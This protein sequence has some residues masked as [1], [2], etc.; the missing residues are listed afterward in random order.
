MA[1]E[2]REPIAP[3][4]FPGSGRSVQKGSSGAHQSTPGGTS[5]S[6][7]GSGQA[8]GPTPGEDGDFPW[9]AAGGATQVEELLLDDI[10]QLPSEPAGGKAVEA[11]AATFPED[12]FFI[13]DEARGSAAGDA[14]RAAAAGK[15]AAADAQRAAKQLEELARVVREQGADGLAERVVSSDRLEAIL[16]G[17]V[18]GYLAGRMHS[19]A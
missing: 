2:P 10:V 3:P 12:A 8:G 5:G 9:D 15:E 17:V 13:P 1:G 6:G 7:P 16:A 11:E 19:G 18:A 4:F 14:G